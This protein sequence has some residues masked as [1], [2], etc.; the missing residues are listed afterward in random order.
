VIT[1][2]QRFADERGQRWEW[3]GKH[4]KSHFAA[5]LVFLLHKPTSAVQAAV[6]HIIAST[7][8]EEPSTPFPQCL[9][10]VEWAD[11]S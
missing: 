8:L 2:P 10:P 4:G 9:T 7:R 3:F 1:A 5:R 11:D 6:L